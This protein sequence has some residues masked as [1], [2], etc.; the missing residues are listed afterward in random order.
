MV[1]Y[2]LKRL[3]LINCSKTLVVSGEK[4]ISIWKKGQESRKKQ[5]GYVLLVIMQGR[6]TIMKTVSW[7]K[8]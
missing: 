2:Y 1:L 7:D 4:Q 3:K 5:N 6:K 8:N